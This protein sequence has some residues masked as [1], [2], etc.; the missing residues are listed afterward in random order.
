[1]KVNRIT[2]SKLKLQWDIL[3]HHTKALYSANEVANH[4]VSEFTTPE[5]FFN[6]D[7]FGNI[8]R[9]S[10]LQALEDKLNRLD[11]LIERL[12]EEERYEEL[13]EVKNNYDRIKSEINKLRRK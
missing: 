4:E 13:Q 11:K 12:L 2:W 3:F 9:I 8:I 7:V 6:R 5:E 10:P 1:M